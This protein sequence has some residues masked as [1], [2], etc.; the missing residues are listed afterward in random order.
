MVLRKM[1]DIASTEKEKAITWILIGAIFF[2]MRSCEY[3]RTSSS[4]ENKRTKILRTRN[5]KFKK[6]GITLRNSST[7]LESADMVVIT[8][9]FQKNKSHKQS[10]HKRT[11]K[12]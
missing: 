9:E 7:E 5:F 12:L 10:V 6:N 3:L 1:S 2:A 11:I 8:F 4:E